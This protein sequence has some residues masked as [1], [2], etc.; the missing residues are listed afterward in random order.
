MNPQQ[1]PLKYTTTCRV[2]SC[3][4]QFMSSPLDLPVVGRPNERLVKFVMAL[5][6]HLQKKH[7]EVMQHISG[8]AQE[9]TGYLAL[10]MFIIEDPHLITGQENVRATLQ[11]FSRRNRITDA[12]ITD[13]VARLGLNAEQEEDLSVLLR[14]MRDVLCEEG[15]YAPKTAERTLVTP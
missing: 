11:Q 13:R 3:G 4:Q 9:F 1:N 14:D 7:P 12:E 6:A 2:P 10:R 5:V 8:M 15:Q